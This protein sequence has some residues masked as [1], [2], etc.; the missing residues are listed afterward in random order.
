MNHESL[1]RH[2][3][4]IHRAIQLITKAAKSWL[5]EKDDDSH[6]N[7]G[8]NSTKNS[9]QSHTFSGNVGI[10]LCTDPFVLEIKKAG[11]IE[12]SIPIIG[13]EHRIIE[14]KM[15]EVMK[16][17]GFDRSLWNSKL[18]YT[19]PYDPIEDFVYPEI[20]HDSMS[21]FNRL[22]S[23][24]QQVF[25]EY[26]KQCSV[27]LGLRTWPH[28]FDLGGLSSVRNDENGNSSSSIGMGLAIHD[29]L[30]NEYYFYINHWN[31]DGISNY[32]DLIKLPNNGQWTGDQPMAILKV[33]SVWDGFGYNIEK[34][35][36]F[37]DAAVKES[38]RFIV[39]S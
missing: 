23:F 39:L 3:E 19:L 7:L 28:H 38:A 36:E 1:N 14:T 21:D 4:I 8:W 18:H 12:C 15:V 6:T 13:F 2:T 37:V 24:G 32:P 9:F 17:L 16:G 11:S 35:L 27:N 25:E 26:E 20:D 33:S 29:S 10:E 31:S 30:S 5:P 22:R 34:T